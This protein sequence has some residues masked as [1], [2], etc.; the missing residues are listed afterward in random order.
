[1]STKSGSFTLS[2]NKAYK[3]NIKPDYNPTATG[4][5]EIDITIDETTN[6]KP[7]DIEVP[8]EWL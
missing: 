8:I 7:V 4:D 6:D 3:L 1:M 5:I 2:R